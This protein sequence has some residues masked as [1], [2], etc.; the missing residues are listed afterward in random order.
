LL[1]SFILLVLSNQNKP[2]TNDIDTNSCLLD[3]F[4]QVS[5]EIDDCIIF[6]IV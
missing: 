4:A 3:S 2:Q 1:F 6:Y 5:I